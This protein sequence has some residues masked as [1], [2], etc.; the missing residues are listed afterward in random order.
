MHWHAYQWTGN[1]ADR[2]GESGRRP[3]SP[4]FPSSPLP[5]MRTGDWLVKPA[6]RIAGSFDDVEDAACWL[7]HEYG[8]ARVSL[9]RPERI[10]LEERLAHARDAL[11]R[12]VDVQWGEWLK[13]G[14][15]VTL[16]MICC[17]NRHVSHPCP[18]RSRAAS[19]AS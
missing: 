19:G 9:I 2:G 8:K 6:S 16:G 3:G 15:F 17:P 4:G 18:V 7:A 13:A 1:G 14:R 5:P 12:G 11:P 10:T